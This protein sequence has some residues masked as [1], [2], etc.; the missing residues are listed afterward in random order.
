MKFYKHNNQRGFTLLEMLMVISIIG[1]LA[2]I[3][4]TSVA[5]A[6]V[7]SRDAKRKLDL[8]QIYNAMNLYF[9]EY[10]CLPITSGTACSGASGYSEFNSAG[11]DYS[12]QG[13]FLPFLQ[14]SGL[15]SSVPVDPVNNGA[16]DVNGGGTGYSYSYYCYPNTNLVTLGAKLE[17]TNTI[18]YKA[19]NV[20]NYYCN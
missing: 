18:Y 13:N 9:S 11:W 15:M 1:L 3:T 20:P 17:T 10:D 7:K 8:N 19:F 14:T 6:R 12:S 2:S 5:S 16:G 4:L